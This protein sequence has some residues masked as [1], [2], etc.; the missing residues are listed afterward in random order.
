MEYNKLMLDN[1]F[2]SEIYV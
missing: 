2:K 1:I